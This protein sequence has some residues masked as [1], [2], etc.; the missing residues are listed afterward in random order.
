MK[1]TTLAELELIVLRTRDRIRKE[2][3]FQLSDQHEKAFNIFA[4]E[5]LKKQRENEAAERR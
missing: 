3:N 5:I 1:T 4:E 2:L